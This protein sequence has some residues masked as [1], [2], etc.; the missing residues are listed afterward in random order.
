VSA[1]QRIASAAGSGREN[2]HPWPYPQ[3]VWQ[4]SPHFVHGLDAL[5]D[6]SRLS[7]AARL[8]IPSTT[9][10]CCFEWLIVLVNNRRATIGAAASRLARSTRF[11]EFTSSCIIPGVD[12]ETLPTGIATHG[13][14]L[15]RFGHALSDPTRARLLL[16]LREGSATRPTWP[17]C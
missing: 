10:R 3:P 16:A 11:N 7:V 15:A 4:A 9:W 17:T 5:G 12:V 8:T 6:D 13:D 14:V 1:S 2:R